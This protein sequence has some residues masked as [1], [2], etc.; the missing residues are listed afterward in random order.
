M[1]CSS[2]RSSIQQEGREEGHQNKMG[3]RG[4]IRER[5]RE[6]GDGDSVNTNCSAPTIGYQADMVGV[7]KGMRGRRGD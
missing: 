7:D 3:E 5:E 1:A 2:T 6:R 4:G